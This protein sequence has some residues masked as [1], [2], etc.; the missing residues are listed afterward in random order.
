MV[1]HYQWIDKIKDWEE[2]GIT[3]SVIGMGF[4]SKT[5]EEDEQH[6]MADGKERA[7]RLLKLAGHTI[8]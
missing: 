1:N 7:T 4:S 6:K 5:G 2:K 3:S 8:K